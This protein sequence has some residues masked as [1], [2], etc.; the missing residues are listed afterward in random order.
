MAFVG[1]FCASPRSSSRKVLSRNYRGGW[2]MVTDWTALPD[3]RTDAEKKTDADGNGTAKKHNGNG[4]DNVVLVSIE[5]PMG[6]AFEQTREGV[7]YV[8]EVVDGS[9]AEG[10]IPAGVEVISVSLP[11]GDSTFPI[12]G[13][14]IDEFES[15]LMERDEKEKYVS[16]EYRPYP[17]GLSALEA[18]SGEDQVGEI[19][20]AEAI[21]MRK[22]IANLPY[23]VL[24]D[25]QS[26]EE[27]S[28]DETGVDAST[29]EML[30]KMTTEEKRDW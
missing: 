5:R 1:G 9:N 7:I 17:G 3:F 26:F 12:E 22:R 6:I 10:K 8:A 13:K 30:S 16:L 14:G 24:Q 28:G 29:L 19:D 21:S 27:P 2:A 11:Y 20:Y 25:E 18:E 15:Y 4:T 23:P